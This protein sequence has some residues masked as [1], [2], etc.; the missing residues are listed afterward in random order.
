M[1]L[2]GPSGTGANS[3]YH[4]AEQH[5]QNVTEVVV[6]APV[7]HLNYLT[8]TIVS[9]VPGKRVSCDLG[10][11]IK[12]PTACL[13]CFVLSTTKLSEKLEERAGTLHHLKISHDLI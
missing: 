2:S 13:G 6:V 10:V 12:S 1:T 4:N 9:S 11:Q 7:S 5:R 8:Y 3:I